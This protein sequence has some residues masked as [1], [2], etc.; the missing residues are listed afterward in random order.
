M[1][2]DFLLSLQ[3]T[4]INF[5]L[6]NKRVL[7]TCPLCGQQSACNTE[8][9][10]SWKIT[11]LVSHV[12]RHMKR[13]SE[14][15]NGPENKRSRTTLHIETLNSSSTSRP[16]ESSSGQ[17]AQLNES[18]SGTPERLHVADTVTQ[19]I[20]QQDATDQSTLIDSLEYADCVEMTDH[21]TTPSDTDN[22]N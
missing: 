7:I 14:L 11:N 19:N 13:N 21:D 18:S 15:E 8:R 20:S 16:S 5:D 12:K 17:S 10:G 4:P 6:N 1:S 3:H 22:L 2:E 9:S